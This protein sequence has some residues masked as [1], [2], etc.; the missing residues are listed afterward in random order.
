MTTSHIRDSLS[1][2]TPNDF[3]PMK[4]EE[5]P[6]DVLL[7]IAKRLNVRDLLAFISVHFNSWMIDRISHM[8]F[9]HAASSASFGFKGP[10]GSRLS[11]GSR[12]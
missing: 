11:S 2:L 12:K 1:S 10:F 5:V 9:R 8:F 6:Q 7:E 4:V 3:S